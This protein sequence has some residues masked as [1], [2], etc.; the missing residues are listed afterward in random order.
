EDQ[1]KCFCH[2][3]AP[4][5]ASI[6][7]KLSELPAIIANDLVPPG[8]VIPD[9]ISGSSSPANC[10][11]LLSVF[12]DQRSWKFFTLCVLILVSF[13]CQPLLCGSPLLVGHSAEFPDWPRAAFSHRKEQ[14]QHAIA[15]RLRH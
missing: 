1:P 6:A 4:V 9:T 15:N 13:F 14:L 11:D 2:T 7:Y 12:T 5:S 10:S 8:V 3:I